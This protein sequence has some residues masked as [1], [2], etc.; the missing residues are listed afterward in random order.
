MIQTLENAPTQII[1]ARRIDTLC[2]RYENQWRTGR[3]P[4]VDDFLDDVPASERPLLLQQLLLIE[5]AYAAEALS[6]DDLRDADEATPVHIGPYRI[7]ATLGRGGFGVVFQAHDE[8]RNRAVAL[9]VPHRESL[10]L[11][12][13]L[14]RFQREIRITAELRH[15]GLAQFVATGEE[16]GLPYLAFEHV[17][18]PTLADLMDSRRVAIDEAVTIAAQVARVL[19]YIHGQRVVHRDIKPANI[20]IDGAGNPRL[21]DFGLARRGDPDPKLTLRGQILGTPAYMSPE[22]AAGAG[23]WA[24]GRSDIYSLGAVLYQML[25]G[26]APF[27][28]DSSQP[29]WS[30]I[31][32]EPVRPRK[33]APNLSRRLERIVLRC[34]KKKPQDRYQSASELAADLETDRNSE[35]ASDRLFSRTRQMT[36]WLLR[37]LVVSTP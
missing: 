36:S 20:L 4:R 17:A 6:D 24:D 23:D 30:A 8:Q 16:R 21:V 37:G 19:D 28:A 29:L 25:T 22:Q 33:L 31:H 5:R 13:Q 9:K 32:H 11:A 2:D 3:R 10:A 27:D 15:P 26:R 34:L 12:G 35:P 14:D 1:R 18:G 7:V